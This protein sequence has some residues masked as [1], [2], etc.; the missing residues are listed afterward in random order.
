MLLLIRVPNH[1]QHWWVRVHGGMQY[2]LM[3]QMKGKQID[4]RIV[5]GLMGLWVDDWCV[6]L[7]HHHH[8]FNKILR[9]SWTSMCQYMFQLINYFLRLSGVAN[10]LFGPRRE[11]RCWW[12]GSDLDVVLIVCLMVGH[13]CMD[14]G[15]CKQSWVEANVHQA[16]NHQPVFTLRQWKWEE[17]TGYHVEGS[18]LRLCVLLLVTFSS[19]LT[20]EYYRVE[21]CLVYG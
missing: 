8:P 5:D 6:C 2:P 20:T 3:L 4:S 14:M 11:R 18:L 13:V 21:G 12:T 10:K 1:L 16:R 15:H 19:Q 17:K 7:T 9:A